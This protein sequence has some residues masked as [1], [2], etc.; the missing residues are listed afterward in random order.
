MAT[1]IFTPQRIY[2]LNKLSIADAKVILNDYID[3]IDF[4]PLD[5]KTKI[6]NSYKTSDGSIQ[7]IHNIFGELKKFFNSDEIKNIGVGYSNGD[8][9]E[10]IAPL[11]KYKDTD[12][13]Q[14]LRSGAIGVDCVINGID[15]VQ[16]KYNKGVNGGIVSFIKSYRLLKNDLKT[17]YYNEIYNAL[18]PLSKSRGLNIFNKLFSVINNIGKPIYINGIEVTKEHQSII[19]KYAPQKDDL[20]IDGKRKEKIQEL[21]NYMIETFGSDVFDM[22]DESFEENQPLWENYKNGVGK[23]PLKCFLD[24]KKYDAFTLHLIY[25]LFEKLLNECYIKEINDFVRFVAQHFNVKLLKCNEEKLILIDM[26]DLEFKVDSWRYYG[27]LNF[28]G[29]GTISLEFLGV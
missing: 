29:G 24:Y 8:M 3:S 18:F 27:E 4:L 20:D 14:Y 9:F 21:Y 25:N 1:K 2:G 26:K 7:G 28:H 10:I 6:K 13:I 17:P 15:N 19:S 22:Y 5:L 16:L 23:K 12:T 11:I